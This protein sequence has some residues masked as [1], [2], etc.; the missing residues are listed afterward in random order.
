MS[1][2]KAA[3]CS[4]SR[5]SSA[6][7]A[8]LR[9][10]RRRRRPRGSES[11]VGQQPLGAGTGPA[12]MPRPLCEAR[13]SPTRPGPAAPG[14]AEP[15]RRL[16]RAGFRASQAGR[17]R[18]LAL[19]LL[20]PLLLGPWSPRA[21]PRRV[22]FS[23]RASFSFLVSFPFLKALGSSRC[24]WRVC[25]VFFPAPRAW[26]SPPPPIFSLFLTTIPDA[27][28]RA[29][30]FI[31]PS[32]PALICSS[33]SISPLDN[34]LLGDVSFPCRD[35]KVKETKVSPA[36]PVALGREGDAGRWGRGLREAPRAEDLSEAA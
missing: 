33:F 34:L 18:R 7:A 24:S 12:R 4:R 31:L 30:S 8:A 21:G 27:S 1:G 25:R 28:P 3:V 16:S 14:Q 6:T 36:P 2:T 20:F 5:G 13:R 9:R 11:H 29:C 26:R 22:P 32:G 19:S 17:A 15:R 23:K 10:V 35:Q